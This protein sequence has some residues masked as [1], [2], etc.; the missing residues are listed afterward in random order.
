MQDRGRLETGRLTRWYP[1]PRWKVSPDLCC[2]EAD[3]YGSVKE[4]EWAGWGDP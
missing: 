4:V 2:K 1:Q 3:G